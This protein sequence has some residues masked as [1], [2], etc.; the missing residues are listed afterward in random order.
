MD[1]PDRQAVKLW[2]VRKTIHEIV[3]DRGYMVSQHELDMSLEDFKS[4]HAASGVVDRSN[5]TFMVESQSQDKAKQLLVFFTEEEGLGIKHVKKIFERMAEQEVMH[6]IIIYQNSMTPS[7]QKIIQEMAP[8][9]RVEIFK[10]SELLVNITHHVLVPQHEVLTEEGKQTLL[11][12]YRLK[13][14]QL[15]RIML[16]DP[17]ARYYG[18][19]RGEV[20]KIIRPSETAGKYVTYRLCH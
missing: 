5:L 2:R 14:S 12:R 11:Q 13:P 1:A 20:V 16:N 19:Q 9:W 18:L 10:E 4:T 17:I 3:R 15:P 8:R 7:A 6:S